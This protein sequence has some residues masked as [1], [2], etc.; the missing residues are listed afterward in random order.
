MGKKENKFLSK[1]QEQLIIAAIQSA[2][3]NTSG[4]IRVHIEFESSTDHFQKALDVFHQLE[5]HQTKERNAVLFHLA[6]NHHHFT[7]IGDIGIDQVTPTDFWENI[8]NEVINHFKKD[9]F[10][11]GLCKGIEMTGIALKNYFPYQDDDI[12]ELPDE[13]SYN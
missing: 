5:M 4:E 13:I 8:K 2:E 6:P 9:Q 11:E 12:N 10:V 1:K 3:K 7:I